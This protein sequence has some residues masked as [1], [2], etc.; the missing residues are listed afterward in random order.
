MII[1]D[2]NKIYHTVHYGDYKIIQ[3]LGYIN[4]DSRLWVRIKFITTG[5]EKNIRY[6]YIGH[7]IQDPYFPRIYGVACM[8]EIDVSRNEYKSDY[9][10][11]ISMI[12][13]CYNP[14]DKD[15]KRYGLAGIR[16]SNDWLIFSNYYKDIKSLP[17]YR[18]KQQNGYYHLDKD[19][20]QQN[21]PHNKMIYSKNTCVWV[22]R[23]INSK[24]VYG[25]FIKDLPY[26]DRSGNIKMMEMVLK[27][28]K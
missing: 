24:L 14:N 9:D 7:D 11:W 2:Y 3:N 28:N 23:S 27:V 20:L 26:I 4:N 8:G 19:Y 12:S 16:V 5:Y 18:F 6:D 13:R 21:V 22:P 25:T 10:R 17:G 1:I 15:Y